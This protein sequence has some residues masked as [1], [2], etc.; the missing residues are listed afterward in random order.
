[1]RHLSAWI[2]RIRSWDNALCSAVVRA[3]GAQTSPVLLRV[4]ALVTALFGGAC[5][6][7]LGGADMAG[8]ALCAA[9]LLLWCAALLCGTKP[10][11]AD[12]FALLLL[13]LLLFGVRMA[14]LPIVSADCQDYLLVW[15]DVMQ[16]L[17]FGEVMARRVGDYTV[18]YQY[19][20]YL[21]ARLP[22]DRVLMYKAFSILFEGL[23]AW[24]AATL[25]CSACAKEKDG[26]LFRAVFLAVLALPTVFINSAVWAQCDAV[27]TALLLAGAALALHEHPAASAA[28]FA[29]SL[30]MKL[31]AVFLLPVIAILL[32]TRKLS[33]RHV[34][35]MGLV[36][37]AVAVPAMLGGKS[38]KDVLGVYLYQMGEYDDLALGAPSIF[39]L[40]RPNDLINEGVLSIIGILLALAA[41]GAILYGG[42]RAA[43]RMSA[44]DRPD[45]TAALIA[46][47]CFALAVCVPVLLP[48]M[49]ERYF[50][51]ADV[52]SL[53]FAALHPKRAYAVLLVVPASLNGY[54]AYLMGEALMPWGVAVSGMLL[55][56]LLA[57]CAVYARAEHASLSPTD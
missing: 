6:A 5:A 2:Q 36:L 17:S 41:C 22:L 40:V 42:M 54:F 26:P 45:E 15:A 56:G 34:V 33:L 37:L 43:L 25:A 19:F 23:L 51:A 47:I 9:V 13:L 30:C 53:V 55:A 32:L 20:V 38:L 4:L 24:S 12:V 52:L 10:R 29:L 57:L 1:M 16:G 44:E 11:L 46:E 39:S 14:A 50:F 3:F 7:L 8:S 21:L 18:L 31:Q 49:H 48:H 27:Y 35:L 28:Y